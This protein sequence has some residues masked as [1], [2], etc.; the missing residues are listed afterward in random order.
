MRAEVEVPSMLR[1]PQIKDSCSFMDPAVGEE[2]ER[3]GLGMERR[4]PKVDTWGK[5]VDS[6]G[7]WPARSC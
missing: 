1:E 5:N 4:H 2:D 7:A 6:I 3:K